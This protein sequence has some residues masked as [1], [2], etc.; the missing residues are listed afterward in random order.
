L[1]AESLFSRAIR[2]QI[3]AELPGLIARHHERTAT[4]DQL[5]ELLVQLKAAREATGLRSSD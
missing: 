5:Q 3:A 2:E 1:L 4:L